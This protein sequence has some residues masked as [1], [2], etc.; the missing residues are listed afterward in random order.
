MTT[1]T[2]Y[3]CHQNISHSSKVEDGIPVI[4][5]PLI[6]QQSTIEFTWPNQWNIHFAINLSRSRT[7]NHNDIQT[8]LKYQ[9]ILC[10]LYTQVHSL[11]KIIDH[12][13]LSWFINSMLYE[14]W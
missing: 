3:H 6:H 10:R 12:F 14:F 7:L 4:F 9:Y 5:Q 8:T 11:R 1:L 2:V 13:K